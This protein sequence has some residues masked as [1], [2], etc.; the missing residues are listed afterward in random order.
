MEKKLQDIIHARQE[1]LLKIKE[2]LIDRL[3]LEYRPEDIDDDAFL[4]GGGLSLDSI[5]AMEIILGMQACFD[6]MIPDGDIAS[7]RTVNT[8]A[9]LVLNE[10]VA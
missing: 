3:Q 10:Q 8:L 5:D 4:F 1:V 6:V 9:D 7:M 2:E